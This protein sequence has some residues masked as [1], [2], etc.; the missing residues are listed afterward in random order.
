MSKANQNEIVIK[1]KEA[2]TINKL[3]LKWWGLSKAK[4][5]K[6]TLYGRNVSII[7]EGR[8][9]HVGE[10]VEYNTWSHFENIN[11]EAVNKIVIA[12]A[13]GKEDHWNFNVMIGLRRI[14]IYGKVRKPFL[15]IVDLT[16]LE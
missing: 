10:G 3:A 2:T 11:M 12:L 8:L 7:Q 5:V 13:D 9:Y 15:P 6:I 16:Q 14:D 4:N 1:L